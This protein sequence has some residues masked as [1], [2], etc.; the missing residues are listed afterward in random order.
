MGDYLGLIKLFAGNYAP[1]GWMICDG[2]LISVSQ[3][4]DLFAVIRT[5][6]GGDGVNTFALP[7][8]RSR[9]PMGPTSAI[10]L[11]TR[12]GAQNVLLTN[13]QM[14]HSH[15]MMVSSQAGTKSEPSGGAS[16]IGKV[17]QG[18]TNYNLYAANASLNVPMNGGIVGTSGSGAPH[19]NMQPY[20]GINYIMCVTPGY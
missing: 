2:S 3:Y 20:L 1:Q 7:D 5:M 11:T 13:D 17:N 12:G 8:L 18:T 6:Y 16:A 14:G 19:N 10:P 15:D 4:A 9:V